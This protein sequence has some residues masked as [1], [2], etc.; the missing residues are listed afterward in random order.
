MVDPTLLI[1]Y[2]KKINFAQNST[3]SLSSDRVYRRL[4]I[5]V[6]HNAQLQ[7]PWSYDTSCL[8]RIY[9]QHYNRHH[10]SNHTYHVDTNV[11]STTH[12]DQTF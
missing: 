3:K 10:Y 9:I 6:M 1:D 8:R 4:C 5:Q 2:Q 7:R 12:R 11:V